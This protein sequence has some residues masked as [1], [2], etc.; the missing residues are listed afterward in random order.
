MLSDAILRSV[1]DDLRLPE[2]NGMSEPHYVHCRACVQRLLLRLREG[3][4]DE[5]LIPADVMRV[6][7]EGRDLYVACYVCDRYVLK[8]PLPGD[9]P[10]PRCEGP[11]VEHNGGLP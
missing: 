7:V 2:G 6:R 11:C 1:L 10:L 5:D 8:V 3:A 9:V 4:P